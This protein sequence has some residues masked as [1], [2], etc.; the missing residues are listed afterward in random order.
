MSA[1]PPARSAVELRASD[2]SG[3]RRMATGANAPGNNTFR[4]ARNGR[5]A[6]GSC[7]VARVGFGF[8]VVVGVTVRRADGPG[9]GDVTC[10]GIPSTEELEL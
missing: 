2:A 3:A 5:E 8:G 1:S 9:S 6:G 7:R 4:M 10:C